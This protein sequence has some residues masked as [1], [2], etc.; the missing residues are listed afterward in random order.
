FDLPTDKFA[1][2]DKSLF[3]LGLLMYCHIVEMDAP[4]EVITNLLRFRLGKGYSPNPY[5][6]FLTEK[7]KKSFAKQGIRTG[8]KIEIIHALSRE[9]SL[10]VGT[11]FDEFYNHRLRNAVQHSDFILTDEQ[12]RSRADLS[13][14]RAFQISY[15][16]LNDV[17]TKAKAFI[18]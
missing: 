9:A 6:D 14:I 16:D 8:R 15:P 18:A 5:F 1:R 17:L 12:F 4:Y 11:V 2:P 13:G 10:T 3:R 7:E